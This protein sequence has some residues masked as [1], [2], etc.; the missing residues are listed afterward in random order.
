MKVGFIGLGHIGAHMAVNLLEAGHEV[1]AY[2]RNKDK[3][4]H[5]AERGGQVADTVAE[6]CQSEV[7]ITMLADDAALKSVVLGSDGVSAQLGVGAIHVS[8]STLT[9]ALAERLT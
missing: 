4:R 6:A 5:F 3:A 8:M 2:N 1:I 7:L 9:V